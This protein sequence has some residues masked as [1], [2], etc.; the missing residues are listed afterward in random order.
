MGLKRK[1]GASLLLSASLRRIIDICKKDDRPHAIMELPAIVFTDVDGVWTDGGMYYD[2]RGNELKRFHTYD[3]AG[4]LFF[5]EFEIPTIILTGEKTS[6]VE[7][8]ASK[9]GLKE[10][11]QGVED[12]LETARGI[13]KEKGLDLQ[14]V[15]YIGDD[16]GDLPLLKRV[17]YSAAPLNAPSYIRQEVDHVVELRGGE[18]AFR[19]FAEHL[20]NREGLLQRTL[21]KLGRR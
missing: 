21:E 11:Y 6:I 19:A 16:I 4:V 5:R 7:E 20:L 8:R 15:A 1:E 9:L 10:L 17:G 2:E 3:S 13:V 14:D 18:G 12:K